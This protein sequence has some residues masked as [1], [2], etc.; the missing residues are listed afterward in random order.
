MSINKATTTV[1]DIVD[2]VA[3]ITLKKKVKKKAFE[4]K[5]WYDFELSKK[6]ILLCEKATLMSNYPGDHYI[7]GYFY[8]C[9]KEYAKMRRY[10][11]KEYS[12]NILDRL[13]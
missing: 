7:R 4:S 10:K 13:D 6:K 9:N 11:K 1:S 2:K 12:Q 8:Q 5:K 3:K